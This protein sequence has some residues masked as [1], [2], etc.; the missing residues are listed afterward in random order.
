MNQQLEITK[1]ANKA[2]EKKR[3]LW[4]K[5]S[6]THYQKNKKAKAQ[7]ICDNKLCVCGNVLENSRFTYCKECKVLARHKTTKK[8][9]KK[10]YYKKQKCNVLTI[11]Y[12]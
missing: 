2:V 1:L 11:Y 5:A 12:Y 9:S 3:E 10:Y 6:A 7:A 4:K 8:A